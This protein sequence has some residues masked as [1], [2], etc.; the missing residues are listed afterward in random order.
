MPSGGQHK[1]NWG[2]KIC[3]TVVR[4]YTGHVQEAFRHHLLNKH[5]EATEQ[6]FLAKLEY[7]LL[8]KQAGEASRRVTNL[9]ILFA[10]RNV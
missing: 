7:D 3:K 8:H 4:D 2:C 6:L 10:E 9:T 5:R 1:T